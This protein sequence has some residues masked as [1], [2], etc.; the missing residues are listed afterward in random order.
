MPGDQPKFIYPV[1]KPEPIKSL[2]K[3]SADSYQKSKLFMVK[4]LDAV[5][6]DPFESSL[7]EKTGFSDDARPSKETVTNVAVDR[8]N[9][10]IYTTPST[11][12]PQYAKLYDSLVKYVTHVEEEHQRVGRLKDISVIDSEPCILIDLLFE[13]IQSLRDEATEGKEGVTQSI[14]VDPKT[15]PDDIKTATAMAVNATQFA[16]IDVEGSGRLYLIAKEIKKAHQE[17]ITMFETLLKA[18]SGFSKDNTPATTEQIVITDIPSYL[19][20]VT[21]VPTTSTSFG[22]IINGLIYEA[23]T[24]KVT[25]KTGLLI[26]AREDPKDLM[27]EGLVK[28][29]DGKT[30]VSL[31]GL[32]STLARLRGENT[33]KSLKFEILPL[34]DPGY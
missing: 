26:R 32:K 17:N 8:I 22:D 9:F 34:H 10:S 25:R 12:R 7:K 33:A 4:L 31:A 14:D 28:R 18:R 6:I 2:S 30:F 20:I 11:K 5:I 16:K 23:P 15:M 27:V 1:D 24:G 13:K 21:A 29:N 19:F 3:E